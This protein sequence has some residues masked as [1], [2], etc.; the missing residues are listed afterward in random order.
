[1]YRRITVRDVAMWHERLGRSA[2][3]I[4]REHDLAL[5]DVYAALVYDV[6]HR[7][8]IDRRIADDQAFARVL[9]ERT[10]S[11]RSDKLRSLHGEG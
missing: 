7:Y 9:R 6:D 10:P 11:K 8:A 2:D 4:A 3:E 1:M 5:A